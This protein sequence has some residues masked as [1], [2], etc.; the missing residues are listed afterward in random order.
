M[1]KAAVL[2]LGV[3]T[4]ISTAAA[5]QPYYPYFASGYGYPAYPSYIY[6]AYTPAYT[7]PAYNYPYGYA[8]YGT[9]YYPYYYETNRPTAYNDP[10]VALRPYSDKAGPAA[11]GH[12]GY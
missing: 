1:I 10:Y 7:Y 3:V 5:A 6:P 11:S 12:T 8:Y 2:G 9:P 4:A